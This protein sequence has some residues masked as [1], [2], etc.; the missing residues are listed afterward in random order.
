MA[1]E[2]SYYLGTHDAETIRL[3]VQHRVWRSHVLDVWRRAGIT[4]GWRAIDAG[5]G[6]GHATL[7]LAEIVGP[8]GRVYALDR[9]DNFRNA[10]EAGARVRGL[11]NIDLHSVDLGTDPIPVAGVDVVF[12]RWV[13]IF[14]A[15]PVGVLKKLAAA[16][17]PGGRFICHDYYNWG[18]M[19]WTPQ[20]P[21]LAEFVET[22]I[23]DWLA[24]AGDINVARR[25]LPALPEAG[26]RLIEA[27]PITFCASPRDFAWQWPKTFVPAHAR[28]LAERGVVS[29][30]WADEVARAWNAA[31]KDPRTLMTT[32]LLMEILAERV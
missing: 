16:L 20:Q 1:E 18:V 5:S 19:S 28:R 7:D 31:E 22:A 6:P 8:E 3:G 21:V 9:S 27:R 15:D 14:M 2:R 13:F 25:I 26:L 32:P 10:I 23:R 17:R 4:T 30:E 11:A 12:I 29:A 24:N